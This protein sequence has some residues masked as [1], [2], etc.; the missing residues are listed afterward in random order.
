MI[1]FFDLFSLFEEEQFNVT[2]CVLLH[3]GN[4]EVEDLEG[5]NESIMSQ[6]TQG[7]DI[8]TYYKKSFYTED[9]CYYTLLIFGQFPNHRQY[10]DFIQDS[11]ALAEDSVIGN[12]KVP[13]SSECLIIDYCPTADKVKALLKERAIDTEILVVDNK[14]SRGA[15]AENIMLIIKILEF[16]AAIIENLPQILLL[17]DELRKKS[18]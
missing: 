2:D 11:F 6:L 3:T 9:Y 18:S 1:V 15:D 5:F 4:Y 16:S 10:S 14:Y 13:A 12:L 17:H 8:W 7:Y